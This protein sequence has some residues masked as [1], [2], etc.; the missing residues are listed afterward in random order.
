MELERYRNY[1]LVLAEMQLGGALQ[2]R[3]Q[4]SDIVQQ[5]LLEAHRDRDAF[6]G[7]GDAELAGWLRKILSNVLL[8]AARNHRAGKRDVAREVSLEEA[9]RRSSMR[10][11]GCLA[12]AGRSPGAAVLLQED[13]V[14]LT[15]ALGELDELQRR[16]IL[17][18][19]CEG[20]AVNE[21]AE[22][23]GRTRAS[24]AGLLRRGLAELRRRLDEGAGEA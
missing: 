18:H 11:A 17:L 16:V 20:L 13:I 22:R 14:S 23:L 4:P 21:I 9:L 6:R 5:A 8:R 10:L 15:D 12:A 24:V 3:V 2:K 7:G 19:H 1:L